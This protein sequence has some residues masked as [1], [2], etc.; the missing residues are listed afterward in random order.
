MKQQFERDKDNWFPRT[1]TEVNKAYDKR[2]PGLFKTEWTGN[3]MTAL[4]SKTYFCRGTEG[5]KLSCKG[6]Q[7]ARNKEQLNEDAFNRSLNKNEVISCQNKGFR[8]IDK[9]IKTYEQNKIALTPIYVKGVVMDDG[10]HIHPL[11]L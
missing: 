5:Y 3:W 10:V 8:F 1:D 7:K 9:D 11:S 6:A 2:K 4:S